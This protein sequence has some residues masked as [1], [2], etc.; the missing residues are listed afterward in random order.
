MCIRDSINGDPWEDYTSPIQ[1]FL[2][3]DFS[4]FDDEDFEAEFAE[5]QRAAEESIAVCMRELGWEYVPVDQSQFI[6]GFNGVGS[7][8]L[9]YGSLEWVAKYGLGI[10]T[11]AFSQFEVGPGLVGFD[12]SDLIDIDDGFEDPNEA[13]VSQLAPA[14]QDAYFADLYGESPEFDETLTEEEQLGL[15]E[16]F[17]P[18]GCQAVAFE[19]GVFGS[20]AQSQ[21]FIEFGSEIDELYSRVESDP[22][23]VEIQAV[24]AQCLAAS[25]H[26]ISAD[27]DPWNQF[28]EL[29][30]PELDQLYGGPA[31]LADPFEGLDP[32]TLSEEEID[33]ILS[34]FDQGPTLSAEQLLLLA[35]IQERE[36]ELAA[37]VLECEPQFFIGGGQSEVFF[38]VLAEYEQA[39]SLIHI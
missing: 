24:F 16:D 20:E 31:D 12:D 9:E 25:G 4:S 14:E 2:G 26:T 11:Q 32:A 28:Y 18:T 21:F 8:G 30:E 5:Q 39:L 17:E 3:V 33:E 22:R 10:T 15:F 23:I 7:D 27:E 19:G 6:G 34:E 38:E 1:E 13:Y 37:D 36:L 29:F 35:E